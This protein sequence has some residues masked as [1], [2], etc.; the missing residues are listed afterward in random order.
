MI[1]FIGVFCSWAI[2][3]AFIVVCS[4]TWSGED[5]RKIASDAAIIGFSS[6]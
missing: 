6:S 2:V 1:P 3:A 4:V 5:T